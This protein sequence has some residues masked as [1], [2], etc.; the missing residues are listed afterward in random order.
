MGTQCST[1]WIVRLEQVLPDWRK[2]FVSYSLWQIASALF[3]DLLGVG[4]GEYDDWVQLGVVQLVHGVGSDV[5]QGVLAAVHYGPD[6]G[7][8]D[9]ARLAAARGLVDSLVSAVV[10]L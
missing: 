2:R 1:Y 7:Q 4:P 3:D 6:G 8:A 10:L 9:D 5:Q